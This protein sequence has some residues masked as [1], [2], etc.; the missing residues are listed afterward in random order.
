ML[1]SSLLYLLLALFIGLRFLRVG[2]GGGNVRLR[3]EGC[4]VEV[5]T[6]GGH[7]DLKHE[8][9]RA[10]RREGLYYT[11]SALFSVLNLTSNL[12]ITYAFCLGPPLLL[13]Y[14]HFNPAF[15]CPFISVLLLQP[16]TKKKKRDLRRGQTHIPYPSPCRG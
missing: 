2:G 15:R 11:P 5:T 6:P 3:S 10:I 14:L 12:I 9:R 13:D 1:S 8:P 7:W 4:V 16:P